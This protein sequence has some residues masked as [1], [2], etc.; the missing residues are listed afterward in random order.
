MAMKQRTDYLA[1]QD[2]YHLVGATKY[3]KEVFLDEN[4]RNRLKAIISNLLQQKEGVELIECTIAYNHVHIL[5]KTSLDISYVGQV[6]FGA[7]SR[8][9]REEYP[10]LKQKIEKGLWGGT[11]FSAIKDEKHFDN[12]QSYIRRHRP[13]NTKVDG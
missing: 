3:R 5:I 12:C 2:Y 11:S 13:D 10:I 8:I 6:V 9:I 1:Y 7:S 4:M